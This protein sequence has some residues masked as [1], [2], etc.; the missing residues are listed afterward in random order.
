MCN[1]VV[2]ASSGL[3]KR[4][5]ATRTWSQNN[6]QYIVSASVVLEMRGHSY[7]VCCVPKRHIENMLIYHYKRNKIISVAKRICYT[8]FWGSK[9]RA[10]SYKIYYITKNALKM[11]Q[12][13]SKKE[14]KN[15]KNHT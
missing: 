3:E 1:H 14:I 15:D 8:L 6:M 2:S 7:E 11:R 13:M 9:T 4:G 10:H 12:D 5:T